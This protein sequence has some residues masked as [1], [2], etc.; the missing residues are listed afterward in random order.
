[1]RTGLFGKGGGAGLVVCGRRLGDEPLSP[2]LEPGVVRQPAET[3]DW[4]ADRLRE[5][6]RRA[7]DNRAM[8]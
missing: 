2:A 7:R 6:H 3:L 1:M 5:E 8:I 4:P